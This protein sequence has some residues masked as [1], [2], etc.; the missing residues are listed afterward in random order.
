M[1]EKRQH[2][3]AIVPAAVRAGGAVA[4]AGQ[5]ANPGPVNRPPKLGEILV[6][7][8]TIT[9]EQLA[10]ALERQKT[11]GRRLGEELVKAGFAKRSMV[12]RALRFQRNVVFGALA[13]L[14]ATSISPRLDAE[15]QGTRS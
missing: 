5:A 1:D 14:A 7:Q 15:P 10:I 8:G 11:S 6:A 13:T 2:R 4:P 9:R 3:A 12:S